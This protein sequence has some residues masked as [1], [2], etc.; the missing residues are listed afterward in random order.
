M[1]ERLMA[2]TL[3]EVL[4][5][6]VSPAKREAILAAALGQN[7]EP[8]LPADVVGFREF[9]RGP[10]R[11]AIAET[12]GDSLAETLVAD[13]ERVGCS[14]PPTG[15]PPAPN[16][17]HRCSS[18]RPGPVPLRAARSLTPRPGGGWQSSTPPRRSSSS[19]WPRTR[20]RSSELPPPPTPEAERG[21]AVVHDM[22]PLASLPDLH[23]H[24]EQC[25][26]PAPP[27]SG[28]VVR[29]PFGSAEY[30]AV[31]ESGG[32]HVGGELPVLVLASRDR[33]V[34]RTI[35]EWLE[36]RAQVVSVTNVLDLLQQGSQ[37]GALVLI[38]CHRPAVRPVAV[39]ALAEELPAATRVVLWGPSVDDEAA[40][41][42]LSEATDRWIRCDAA[43][44]VTLAKHCIEWV[45]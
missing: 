28:S 14:I 3:R 32:V 15:R 33:V 41:A 21:A 37:P 8:A 13:L 29:S 17:V 4:D 27:V 23:A 24:L 10:L 9:V 20:L 40:I 38:D 35:G 31:E 5:T 16:P 6:V 12:L 19:R 45:S 11:H 22:D 2:T 7:D 26:H 36:D 1:H 30:P 18:L 42:A 44:P 34:A 25:S 43:A 39:A